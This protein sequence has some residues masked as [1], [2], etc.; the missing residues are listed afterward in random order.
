MRRKNRS[1]RRPLRGQKLVNVVKLE[2]A[3]MVNLDP[4]K[5]PI[6]VSSVSRRTQLSRQALYANDLLSQIRSHADLQR[7]TFHCKDAKEI[8]R[9]TAQERITRLELEILELQKKIDGWLERWVAVEYNAK[10][11]GVDP[12]K[13][14]AS[15]PAPLRSQLV[16]TSRKK[17]A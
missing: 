9:Q 4:K 5:N 14:F 7:E 2:L 17:K 16:F 15:I 10:M 1:R 12:D 6:N 11:Q 8:E 3:R 13:I